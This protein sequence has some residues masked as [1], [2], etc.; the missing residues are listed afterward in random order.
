MLSFN[1]VTQ[2]DTVCVNRDKLRF[3]Q[4][5]LSLFLIVSVNFRKVS[6]LQS[7]EVQHLVICNLESDRYLVVI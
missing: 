3:E 4:L 5:E 1:A 2:S 6:V 7:I